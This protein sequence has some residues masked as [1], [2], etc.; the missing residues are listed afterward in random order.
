MMVDSVEGNHD[1]RFWNQAPSAPVSAHRPVYVPEEGNGLHVLCL[2]LAHLNEPSLFEEAK[3]PSVTSFRVSF[4]SPVPTREIA[5]RLLIR[6]DGS[7]EISS[8]FSLGEGRETRN[9]KLRVSTADVNRFLQL[10][11]LAGFWAAPSSETEPQTDS[12]G[13]KAYVLDGAF[14]MLEGVRQGSF[15]Y[16]FR[17]NPEG[18]SMTEVGYYLAKDLLRPDDPANS[19][20]GCAFHHAWEQASPPHP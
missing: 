7:G 19:M 3:D 12:A 8:A 14:W 20:P 6:A 9:S 11:E 5:I 4:F 1:R 16:V 13:R 18:N 17:R 2:I 15:H 10:I